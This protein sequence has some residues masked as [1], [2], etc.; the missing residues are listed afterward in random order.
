M[1]TPTIDV[2][3]SRAL[4]AVDETAVAVL[5]FRDSRG[6]PMAWPVTPYID[7]DTV[8]VTSTLAY[9]RKPA[10]LRRDGSGASL[11]GRFPCTRHA[12]G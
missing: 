3:T 2:T 12:R 7:G 9:I 1:S 4:E 10:H 5:A 8:V 11:C 6:Q